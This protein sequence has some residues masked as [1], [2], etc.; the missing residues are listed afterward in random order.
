MNKNNQNFV[1]TLSEWILAF[2]IAG[3]IFGVIALWS[4]KYKLFASIIL[5]VISMFVFFSTCIKNDN[6][7]RTNIK[8]ERIIFLLIL[9]I[10]FVVI[11]S[12]YKFNSNFIDNINSILDSASITFTILSGAILAMESLNRKNASKFEKDSEEVIMKIRDIQIEYKEHNIAI[13][14]LEEKLE[15]YKKIL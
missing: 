14:K 8:S 1:T 4:S 11:P 13:I 7:W 10:L 3:N 2:L 15:E 12:I 9:M 5:F 6:V